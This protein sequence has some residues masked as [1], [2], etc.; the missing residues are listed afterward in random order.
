MATENTG[1]ENTAME[2]R[3]HN[4][5][6]ILGI[7]SVLLLTGLLGAAYIQDKKK[8]AEP[9]TVRETEE[10]QFLFEPEVLTYGGERNFD[11][12][13]GIS[14]RTRDGTDVTD[15]VQAV[16]TADGTQNEKVIRYTAFDSQGKE[17]TQ[18]RTLKMEDYKGP[19][20]SVKDPLQI[21]A[22][23]LDNL[24]ETLGEKGD[25]TAQDGFGNDC[26]SQVTWVRTRLSKGKYSI[27]F[28]LNNSFLDTARQTVEADITGEVSDIEL[29]LTE[30]S[31]TIPTGSEFYPLD[32]V[33]EAL[34]PR[35]GSLLSRVQVN[36][37]VDV[38]QPGRYQVIYTVYSLDGTQKA[39]AVLAVTV[40]GEN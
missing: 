29:H 32:Y 38:T 14:A 22:G 35:Q 16:L 7:V 19:Q 1:M 5:R 12:M 37:L 21:D 18:T 40:T 36:N 9:Q 11:F 20:L 4:R 24:A 17:A 15:T 33:Q 31:I 34:D 2:K 3:K 30:T 26:I 10:I 13:K 6:V 39:E 25:L 8:Q 28:T 27:T 23:E